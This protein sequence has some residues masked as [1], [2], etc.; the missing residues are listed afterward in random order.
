MKLKIEGVSKR[1]GNFDALKP[2][3]LEVA[4]GEF[5]TLL[6]PSGSGK[7][8]LLNI[9]E[10]LVAPDT[11]DLYIGG[12]RA[13]TEPP[14]LRDIGM[15]FQS[16]ALFPHLSI[17]ENLAFPLRMRRVPEK[18]VRERV[19]AMLELIS[20]PH[21]ADRLPKELS[22]GQQQR[23]ALGRALVY[24]PSIVL[25]DEPLG[26]LDKN[27]REQMQLEIKHLHKKLG[28]TII[29]VTHDQE[30]A[31]AMSDRI[32]LMNG[33]EIEQIGTPQEIYDHPRT[34]FA[35]RFIGQSNLLGPGEVKAHDGSEV[36]V[37]DRGRIMVRPEHVRIVECP[38][39]NEHFTTAQFTEKVNLGA[40]TRYLFRARSGDVLS[41]LVLGG[42]AMRDLREGEEATLAWSADRH[43]VVNEV[44][45]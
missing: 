42:R 12:K 27:L 9:I 28:A 7:T 37:A 25:M 32:C 38:A 22:G 3:S 33:G 23:V 6:G 30:E 29:Y 21:I 40:V 15:V 45:E 17:F 43:V 34:V 8:T 14:Y 13:T 35:A 5:L 19:A 31:L 41:S 18:E 36:A 44:R 26:A 1:Y 2:T 24:R 4:E 10:G 20:L 39:E 11:G 16:Y